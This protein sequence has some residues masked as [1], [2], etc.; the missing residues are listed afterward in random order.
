MDI[1]RYD[2]SAIEH[3]WR[4]KWD[5]NKAFKV[6]L[7]RAKKPFYNLM[8]FPYPSGEG[9]HVGHVYAFGGSDTYGRFKR[10][11]GEDVFEPMGFDS[12]GIHSENY[13]LKVGTHPKKLISETTSY[14][15]EKQLKRLGALFDWDHQVITSDPD[16]YRWTQWIFIQLF[17]AG[18]ALRK[19]A[20]VDWCPSCKTTLADEQVING[21]CERC[22]AQVIQRELEQWF[23]KIT[24]Y[25]EKLLKNLDHIDW[26]PTT[27]SMQRNWIGKSEGTIIK[28]PVASSQQTAK[29][30]AVDRNLDSGYYI[31]VFTTRPDTVFGATFMVIA[32]EHHLALKLTSAKSHKAVHD[33]IEESK[34]VSEIERQMAK[35]GVFTGSYCINPLTRKEIPVWV[36]D[37]VLMGYGTG[38][39][40]GVPAHDSRD[41]EFAKAHKLKIVEVISGG[42]IREKAYIGEGKLVNSGRF[43]G[44]K[45]LEAIKK[46]SEYIENNHLGKREVNYHLRDWLISRQRYWGPPI[47]MIYCD[48]CAQADK[49]ERVKGKVVSVGWYSVPE[50]DLP[51]ILPELEDYQPKGKGI[52][53]LST[54]PDFVSVKCPGCGKGAKRETDVSDTFL[55]S[56]WYFLR[57]PSTQSNNEA[58]D[59]ELTKK[60]LPVD[61]YIGGNEH[62]V[63]HLLYT[64]FITMALKDMGWI[65]F[66]E[67]FKKFRAHGLIIRDGAKM[68]KSR[69][70]V[71]NPNEYL[72]AYG[73]DA[74]RTY[75]LFIGPYDLG[76]DFSDRAIVG[77]HRFLNRVWQ[78]VLEI[79]NSPA[80]NA[81]WQVAKEINKVIKKVGEDVEVLK[82]N[83]A[84]AAI[85]EFNNFAGKNKRAIDIETLKKYLIVISIFT[86]FIAEELW[87]RI[88]EKASVHDQKWPEV[89]NEHLREES[90]TVVVQVNGKLRDTLEIQISNIRNQKEIEQLALASSKVKKYI[91]GKKV[92]KVIYVPGKIVNIVT[93]T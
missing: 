53:P 48:N 3:K 34:K 88:G 83:T 28:F 5:E 45:N 24:D 15:R 40:M 62:A 13:A 63:M 91:D 60:W 64:R 42:N 20:P 55:D 77:V 14:F 59:S 56:S 19:K 92:K 26:S 80:S 25:A 1:D 86:P 4:K 30:K 58:F 85:M 17:K 66:E 44:I 33:Y 18:L 74:L 8:M 71:V 23:F 31:E 81:K 47:P 9:L 54:V 2:P 6:D 75:L 41:Y 50:K 35:T 68:S 89:E 90:A 11:Q 72:D 32:P 93:S 73:P 84:I 67:P 39:I 36:A 10:L 87:S 21:R 61:M 38:A 29:K 57:Y 27:K 79:S 69:G 7:K 70:N 78:N 76:G 43:D 37:Y 12:F 49:G 22:S 82:F 65:D 46:V 51:V 16:Y 52:S